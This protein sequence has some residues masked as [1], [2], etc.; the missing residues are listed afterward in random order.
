MNE[1][2]NP[3]RFTYSAGTP[4]EGRSF[5]QNSFADDDGKA[6]AELAAAMEAFRSGEVGI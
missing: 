3:N 4:L 1:N 5:E 6:P 2:L